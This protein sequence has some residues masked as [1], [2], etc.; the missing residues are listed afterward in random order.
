MLRYLPT[1]NPGAYIN[2]RKILLEMA[3]IDE[4]ELNIIWMEKFME[5]T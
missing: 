1:L 2:R 3:M 5:F 4:E